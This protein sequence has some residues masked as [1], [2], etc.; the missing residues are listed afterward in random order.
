[1]HMLLTY[2]WYMRW[3]YGNSPKRPTSI[4]SIPA[5]A[6][7]STGNNHAKQSVDL[8]IRETEKAL[9]ELEKVEDDAEVYKTAGNLLIKMGKPE[10]TEEMSEKLETLKLRKKQ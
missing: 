1:M 7:A 9:E 4:S 3:K 10:L 8:Q 2:I 5:D 6:A